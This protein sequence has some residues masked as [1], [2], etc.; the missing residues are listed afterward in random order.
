[1][2]RGGYYDVIARS[3]TVLLLWLRVHAKRGISK[4]FLP[5]ANIF[6]L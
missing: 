5:I 6:L 4:I 3:V 1:M 2:K